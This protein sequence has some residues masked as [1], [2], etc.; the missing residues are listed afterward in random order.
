MRSSRSSLI[1]A[2]MMAVAGSGLATPVT[3]ADGW[4]IPTTYFSQ[5]PM[6]YASRAK[7]RRTVAQDKREARKRRNRLRAK[8]RA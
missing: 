6:L 1:A 4:K 8:G 3:R 5:K 2:A 7:S